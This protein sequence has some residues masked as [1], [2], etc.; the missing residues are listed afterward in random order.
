[1]QQHNEPYKQTTKPDLE[2]IY[3][4]EHLRSHLAQAFFG[5]LDTCS[6]SGHFVAMASSRLAS[7]RLKKSE[8]ATTAVL[9]ELLG[10]WMG[11]RG[12]RDL[13]ALMRSLSSITWKQSPRLAHLM[14]FEDQGDQM[15]DLEPRPTGNELS[16]GDDGDTPP[17]TG[18]NTGHEPISGSSAQGGSS[19]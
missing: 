4:T 1:M 6:A 3:K 16:N 17:D 9:Y 7:P 5:V 15:P 10:R 2:G 13:L 18:G 19:A 14:E 12:S 11:Q 8:A